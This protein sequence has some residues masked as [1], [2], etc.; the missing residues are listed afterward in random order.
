MQPVLNP[1]RW[2]F[3]LQVSVR[4]CHWIRRRCS[5]LGLCIHHGYRSFLMLAAAIKRC[6]QCL[7]LST[8]VYNFPTVSSSTKFF[9]PDSLKPSCQRCCMCESFVS[10]RLPFVIPLTVIMCCAERSASFN[11][12]SLVA[13]GIWIKK[14]LKFSPR[15]WPWG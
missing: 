13:N 2:I 5:L 11:R 15:A 4:A 9:P 12:R 8:L 14:L 6:S 10:H 1:L 7:M 3:H